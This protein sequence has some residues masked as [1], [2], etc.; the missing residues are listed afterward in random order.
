MVRVSV[1]EQDG[2][3]NEHPIFT[4][5]LAYGVIWRQK[6]AYVLLNHIPWHFR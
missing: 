4:N 6:M 1:F 2:C 3:G 5:E